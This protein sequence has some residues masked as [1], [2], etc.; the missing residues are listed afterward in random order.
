MY[1]STFGTK[2]IVIISARI[3]FR[4]DI[5]LKKNPL[6]KHLSEK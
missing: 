4:E 5:R 1:G 3:H 2:I 6:A